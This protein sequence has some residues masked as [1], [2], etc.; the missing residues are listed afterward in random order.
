MASNT[1]QI[2]RG[3]RYSFD[4]S[5]KNSGSVLTFVKN[6]LEYEIVELQKTAVECQATRLSISK[7]YLIILNTY[8]PP[9]RT[10]FHM[11]GELRKIVFH[12]KEKYPLDEILMI[13]DFNMSNIHWAYDVDFPGFL[14][15]SSININR[16][17]ETFLRV[18]Y[19]NCLYQI[20]QHPNSE[21]KFL[22]LVF[23]TDIENIPASK[24]N[25]TRTFNVSMSPPHFR[26]VHLM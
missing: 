22:D 4:V 3:N 5:R 25:W 23:S 9:Y 17:E 19:E 16:Q 21:N 2:N 8:I 18:C 26:I 12:L 6:G 14:T 20:N 1:F 24:E 15:Q 10:R 7:S 13:G 11:L